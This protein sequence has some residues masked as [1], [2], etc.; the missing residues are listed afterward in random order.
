MEPVTVYSQYAWL[1]PVFPLV[2]FIV[3]TA[4]GRGMRS[5]GMLI[6]MLGSLAAL[7]LSVLVLLER[8]TNGDSPEYNYSFDWITIGDFQLN[9]GYDVTNLSALML[10]VVSVVAFLVNLYSA[11]YLKE[12][13]RITV[14]FGYVALFT[15]SMLG[16]VLS[17]N[18]LTLYMFWELVG[19]C[20][21]LL[22]GFWYTKPEARAA[23]KKAFIVTRVGDVGLLIA[24]LL[25][26]WYMPEH[27][28][29]FAAIENVFG[30][31]GTIAQGITT[32]I[33]ILIF[34]GAAGKSG[35][36]PLHV[37]LPDAME[38]PTPISALIHAA[39]MVAAGVFLVARTY[40]IFEASQAAMDT[41]AYV[42]AFTALFAATIGL[43]QN[44]IKR[45]LAYSTV[46]QLGY[47]MLA[48]GVGSLSGGIFHL[49]THA[50][51]K[52]LLFLG[53][54]SVIHAVHTQNIHEMGGLGRQ[55]KITAWTFGIGAL[56]LTGI[57][58]FS[59]FWSKDAILAVALDKNPFLFAVGILTAFFTALYMARLY[60]LV[61]AGKSGAAG[62]A[63]ESP[64]VMTIPL[65]VLAAFA[66]LSGFVEL[67][68][69]GMGRLGAW[70]TGEEAAHSGSG[71]V[72]VV[73][74]AIG[75]LGIYLGWLIYVKGAIP[76]D[77]ISSRAPWLVR[78]L[79]RKYYIDE[80]Y[81]A[82]FTVGLRASGR[83]LD[84]FDT[85]IV[86][87]AVRLISGAAVW[88]GRAGTRM[89][90]GQVQTYGL[91]T[92]I[93]LLALILAIAGRRFW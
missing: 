46:S 15:F 26:F 50:F 11:G 9:A 72:L 90:N 74:T 7:V 52:A 87:G 3:L 51:F 54:G 93:G 14:F 91:W 47:M 5:A 62:K 73:S 71:L 18:L 8:M 1:I 85:Y 36:F 13:E 35:Q 65:V 2:S 77:F 67:P 22:V 40:S 82:V 55:M 24:V 10:F 37:W 32:L 41:V 6:G 79:E 20:S 89:Q 61:F 12:D 21:F 66:A 76:R 27:D 83:A 42:G 59:G 30:Q 29:S 49:F 84:A 70:L 45:I 75:L 63:H 57:P 64:A 86:G 17:D 60:F 34:V 88:A 68:W 16:L 92:V 33:A 48:L 39:T 53:A 80:L 56:A 19:V 28:L 4:F 23:A 25:L 81:H 44:D 31:T 58:P 69:A 43:V 38:G 78:L